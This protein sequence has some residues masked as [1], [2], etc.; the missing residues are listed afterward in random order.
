MNLQGSIPTPYIFDD[1]C[2]IRDVADA[3]KQWYDTSAADR[4]ECGKLGREWV[5]SEESCMTAEAM[6]NSI[7]N[8][9]TVVLD[10]WKPVP[11]FTTYNVHEEL[12]KRKNK[13][14]GISI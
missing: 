7:G 9:M 6:C 12:K 4:E 10:N 13:K 2:N 5:T 11:R 14:T 1:R 8:A 3:L